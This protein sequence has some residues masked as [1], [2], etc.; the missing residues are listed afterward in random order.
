MTELSARFR[1]KGSKPAAAR[2]LP[3]VIASWAL[4]VILWTAMP[5]FGDIYRYVDRNGVV[6]FTN[7]PMNS[8][9]K[10]YLRERTSG[11]IQAASYR[12]QSRSYVKCPTGGNYD[13]YIAEAARKHGVSFSLIKAVIRAESNFDPYAVSRVGACGLMQIMPPTAKDLGVRDPFDP[14]EN[15]LG[16]TRYL[17]E[18]LDQFNGSV[19]LAL[20]AY[21]AG[22]GK[23][24]SVNGV[25]AIDET[26]D[27]V[28]RVLR[29]WKQY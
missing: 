18:L 17:S 19:P 21:N 22:P 1:F 14:R 10:V 13:R 2:L 4:G 20:A 11:P 28:R 25:P 29:F 9:Y 24:Q 23:V 6:H 16:G 26:Q 15:I 3:A 8:G 27:F 7:T 5:A 12:V